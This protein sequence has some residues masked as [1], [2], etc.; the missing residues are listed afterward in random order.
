MK[1]IVLAAVAMVVVS[2]GAWAVLHEV[3]FSAADQTTGD[4]VRLE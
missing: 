4:A 2:V 3:G 1:A